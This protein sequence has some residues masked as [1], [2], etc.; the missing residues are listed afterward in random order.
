MIFEYRVPISGCVAVKKWAKQWKDLE[1]LRG[2][3]YN[4][5][6]EAITVQVTEAGTNPSQRP[7]Q[8][9]LG[10]IRTNAFLN[11]SPDLAPWEMR[12]FRL[13]STTLPGPSLPFA[14]RLFEDTVKQTPDLSF[15]GTTALAGYANANSAA[16]LLNAHVV[17]E[18]LSGQPFL[19]GYAPL[20][21]NGAVAS[22]VPQF[23]WNGPAITT[24]SVRHHL[25]LN[26][27]N[28][29]HG[30]ET[31]TVFMHVDPFGTLSRFLTGTGPRGV[32]D[33]ADKFV[34]H[35][36]NDLARRRQALEE[37]LTAS[38]F[39]KY[40]LTDVFFQPLHMTH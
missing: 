10:Q 17:P 11:E 22:A 39:P 20:P 37:I 25:S 29:C 9:S 36:F 26:T 15:N 33:P 1:A 32:P 13:V 24:S 19:A 5:A 7:N 31:G 12:E 16:I 30:Q 21:G 4:A 34:F 3:T 28:G 18:S 40:A 2:E 6:L 23:F 8:S 27:C 35:R 14:G 38:C